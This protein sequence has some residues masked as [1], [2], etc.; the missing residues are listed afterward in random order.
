MTSR[1]DN[2]RFLREAEQQR[3]AELTRRALDAIRAL[4]AAGEAV[5]FSA[6]SRAA[7]CSRSFLNRHDQ[8]AAEI[9]RHRPTTTIASGQ[10]ATQARAMTDASVKARLDQLRA[11]NGRLRTENTRLRSQVAGLLQQLRSAS[12]SGS[13]DT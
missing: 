6:V 5:T 9:R 13:V 8:L 11:D 4:V 7:G 2:S 1:P 3:H 12:P 10:R